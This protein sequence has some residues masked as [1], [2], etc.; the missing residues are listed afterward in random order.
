[1]FAEDMTRLFRRADPEM[2]EA[3]KIRHLMR[4]VKEQLFA[5]LLRNPP[6]T[7]AEF[8][9]E[10]T[11]IERA[12]QQRCRPFDRP[13]NASSNVSAL[14][15]GNELRE[16]IREVVR[17]EIRNLLVTPQESVGASVAEVVRQEIRQAFSLPESL[18][19][20][21]SLS[22]A[23]AVRRPPPAAA[24]NSSPMARPFNEP[25]SPPYNAQPLPTQPSVPVETSAYFPPQATAAWPQRT[26]TS[27]P[28]VR[29]TEM[30]RTV[31]R[32]PLCFH[33]GEA[34]HVYRFC[35][36]RDPGYQSFPPTFPRV[37]FENRR[38]SDDVAPQGHPF[39]RRTRSPSPAP[40]SS[41][42]GRSYADVVRGGRSPSP[43][44]GN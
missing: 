32:R 10:A 31:D 4:G 9:S 1:M 40:S 22:Y 11:S 24:Y 25:P 12:L 14:A 15:A 28:F 37:R 44:R 29:R 30:W 2:P 6:T 20:Q 8:I 41:P 36:Y 33:C 18:P 38:Y 17:E 26:P 42:Q 5:G 43:R 35:P 16:L 39:T 23:S 13:S 3:K 7:V 27:R 21:R 19:D 34:G